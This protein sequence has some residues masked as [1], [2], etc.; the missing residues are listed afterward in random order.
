M[1]EVR[2]FTVFTDHKPLTYVS[3][4]SFDPYSREIRH[5]DYVLQFT[6]GIRHVKGSDNIDA[7]C[8][9]R[10][11]VEAVTKAVHFHSFSGAQKT[12]SELQEF[13]NPICRYKLVT[14]NNLVALY[15]EFSQR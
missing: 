10:T 3:R 1:K 7:D 5:P 13:R 14:L 9:S 15:K 2:Q 11:D 6:N 8:L 12:D 4:A